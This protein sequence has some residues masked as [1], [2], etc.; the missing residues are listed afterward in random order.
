MAKVVLFL[1]NLIAYSL[2][3]ILLILKVNGNIKLVRYINPGVVVL[4]EVVSLLRINR[5]LYT[6]Q[7]LLPALI[8]R[9]K[10]FC[11]TRVK[12]IQIVLKSMQN[13]SL[14]KLWIGE[15]SGNKATC[16]FYTYNFRV[17]WIIITCHLKVNGP[18]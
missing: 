8:I 15:K 10:V 3:T 11:G 16:L 5:P 14:H 18:G 6:M 17:L 2:V 12:Q 4:A 13:Y 9:L 7:W 1:I